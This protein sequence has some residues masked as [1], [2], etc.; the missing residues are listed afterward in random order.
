MSKAKGILL[1]EHLDASLSRLDIIVE[2]VPDLVVGESLSVDGLHVVLQ[3]DGG[4]GSCLGE[5][6]LELLLGH[7]LGDESNEDV[8]L[9]GLL[10]VPDN[11]VG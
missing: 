7:I 11:W 9:E 10:L 6:G 5:L 8:G 4:N 1:V 2:D 3:L